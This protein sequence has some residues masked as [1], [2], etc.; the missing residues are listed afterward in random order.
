MIGQVPLL[1]GLYKVEHVT[2]A[3]MA[4]VAQSALTLDELHC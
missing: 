1:N 3:A 4:N 2:T